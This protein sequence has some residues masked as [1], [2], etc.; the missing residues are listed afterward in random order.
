MFWRVR[1]VWASARGHL[2]W[3]TGKE[4]LMPLQLKC[5]NWMEDCQLVFDAISI[6]PQSD[7]SVPPQVGA[8]QIIAGTALLFFC[9][10]P[11]KGGMF[12]AAG[13]MGSYDPQIIKP[14]EGYKGSDEISIATKPAEPA[15]A[16]KA[17]EAI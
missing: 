1:D 16:D 17:V 15:E 7:D 2:W 3:A 14:P 13:G 6:I 10:F 11:D 9:Y 12:F 5:N 4:T 8:A